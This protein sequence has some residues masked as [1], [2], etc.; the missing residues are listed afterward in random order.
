MSRIL[1]VVTESCDKA[2]LEPSE[3]DSVTD[4]EVEQTGQRSGQG[5]GADEAEEWTGVE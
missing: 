3:P 5:G 1:N 2:L 4:G